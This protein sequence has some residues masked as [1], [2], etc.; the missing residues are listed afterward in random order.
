MRTN[1]FSWFVPNSDNIIILPN[2]LTIRILKKFYLIGLCL[3]K[4]FPI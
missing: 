4:V 2:P 1:K 3:I